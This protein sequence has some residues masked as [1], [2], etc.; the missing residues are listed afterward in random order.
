VVIA[1]ASRKTE[2]SY[3]L[4]IA[5]RHIGPSTEVI[6]AFFPMMGAEE[7]TERTYLQYL[8][9]VKDLMRSAL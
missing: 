6:K 4:E 1:A 5:A 2:K 7:E 3:A 9:V 8:E